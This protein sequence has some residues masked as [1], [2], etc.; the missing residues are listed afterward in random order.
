MKTKNPKYIL[1]L[2]AATVVLVTAAGACTGDFEEYNHNPN[3]TTDGEL[4]RD[5]Y[6]V[7]AKLLQLQNEVVP[8]QEHLYQFTEILAGMAYG[9]YSEAIPTW[10]GKFST[11]NPSVDWLKAPFVTLMTDTYAPYR[12][13]LAATE[14]QVPLALASLLRVAI[15]H[16]LT[17]QYGPIPYSKVVEDRKNSLTVAYDTQQEVYTKMFGELDAALAVLEDNQTLSTEAF[18]EYDLVYGGD[19]K[20]WIRFANSLK[21]RMAMRLTEVAPETAKTKAAEAIAAGVIEANADNAKFQPTVNRTAICFSEWKQHPISAD[22]D[23]YMNGYADPRRAKM[24]T[25]VEV[26]EIVTDPET[27]QSSTVKRQVFQGLRIGTTP[28]DKDAATTKL[29]HPK[30]VDTDPILWLTAAEVAFLRAEWQLR[31]GSAA[32]A[33]AFYKRGVELSFE[34]WG[35]GSADAYLATD[36]RPA[37][38]TDPLGTGYDFPAQGTVSPVWNAD[39]EPAAALERIITQKWIAIFP[40]GNEAWSEYRRTGYPRLMPVPDQGNMSGGAVTARWGARRLQYPTEEYA[41]NRT[42]VTEAVNGELGGTDTF[43]TRV[44]WDKRT[45]N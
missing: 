9:G 40:L 12:G 14:D 17:D 1:R 26:D 39:D 6:N 32:E 38:Y 2:L 7:G 25:S 10:T 15:M 18:G 24:F 45:L 8:S 21:L 22:L 27:Q 23:S 33:G 13:I 41:E 4:E 11:F 31:W 28:S 43:G 30:I 20:K 3:E 16:R 19:L 44:W 5:N 35:A 34:Q 37:N 36:A 42:H 29:S